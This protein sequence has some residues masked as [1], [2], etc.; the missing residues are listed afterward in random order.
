MYF[1]GNYPHEIL[2]LD[3]LKPLSLALAQSRCPIHVSGMNR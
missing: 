1:T 2:F 3:I